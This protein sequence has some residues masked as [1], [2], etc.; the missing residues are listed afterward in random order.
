MHRFPR[1]WRLLCSD[2]SKFLRSVLQVYGLIVIRCLK[3]SKDN[4]R[5]V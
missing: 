1:C 4:M 5:L 3:I 2:M